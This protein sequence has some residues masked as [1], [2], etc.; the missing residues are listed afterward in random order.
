MRDNADLC[1]LAGITGM[2]SSLAHIALKV[3]K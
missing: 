2:I 1:S 3:G